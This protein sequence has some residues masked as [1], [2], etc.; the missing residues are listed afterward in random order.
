MNKISAFNLIKKFVAK[1]TY[2]SFNR[3]DF[4]EITEVELALDSIKELVV[5]STPAEPI[6]GRIID[7]PFEPI[8]EY[9]CK[10]GRRLSFDNRYCPKC[11]QL[12]D[13]SDA[14]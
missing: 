1:K 2:Y 12:I 14:R 9:N 5:K 13:W 10:C 4:E 6:K 8:I 11:G 7:N 3:N